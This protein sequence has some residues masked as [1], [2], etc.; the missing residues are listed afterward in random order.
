MRH[1]PPDYTDI[2]ASYSR[3]PDGTI[4]VDNRAHDGEGELEESVGV[5]TFTDAAEPG[6]LQV[7]FLPEGLRWIPFTKGDYWI[8]RVDE[9]YRTA[10]VGSPD[11]AYLW[12]LHREPE[13]DVA[14]RDMFL[15]YA[16]S[17]GY[18]LEG[19][20]YTPHTRRRTA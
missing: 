12:L 3:Q 8:L 4:R 20:V 5:A 13:L 16:R 7:S 14:T 9:G 11:Y 17:L 1:E 10:L 15:A 2:S 19:L 6:R 18:A